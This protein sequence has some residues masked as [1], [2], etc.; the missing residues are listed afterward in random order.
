MTYRHVCYILPQ[1]VMLRAAGNDQELRLAAT[2]TLAASA[3]MRTNRAALT[4]M[5]R[6]LGASV[7]GPQ[8]AKLT[9]SGKENTVYDVEHG[10]WG[11]LPGK[12]VRGVGDPP[13]KDPAVN[14]AFDNAAK[15]SEFYKQVLNRDSI[16]DAGMEL[17]SSV[18]FDNDF[19]NAFWTGSQMVYGDGSDRFLAKGSLTR[20]QVVVAHELTHGVVQFTAGLRY[21][22]QSGALNEHFAD[23]LGSVVAQWAKNEKAGDADWLVGKGILG[24]A[25]HGV[26]LR[27]MKDPGTAFD[28]DPQ[29]GH[30]REYVD[31]PDDNDPANDHGGVHINSGIPNKAFYLAATTIGGNAWEAPGQIWYQTLTERLQPTSDFREAA[32]ATVDAAGDLFGSGGSEEQAVQ[33]AWEEVG[34]VG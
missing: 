11:D 8:I 32:Q 9:P 20:D 29:V 26:A 12:R 19:D 34:V 28:R 2:N 23:A 3:S 1:V 7:A 33:R 21:S 14:E 16:D 6:L 10:S 22:K 18:H 4:E 15:T 25:V 5:V 17:V 31:L 13:A 24:P 27:S 30:M